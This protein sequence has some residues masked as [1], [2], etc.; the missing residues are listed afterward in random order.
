MKKQAQN[1]ELNKSVQL[2]IENL[3]E[4]N[5]GNISVQEENKELIEELTVELTDKQAEKQIMEDSEQ[6]VNKQ[7]SK[8]SKVL[9]ALFFVINIVVVACILVFQLKNEEVTAI[10]DLFKNLKWEYVLVIFMCFSVINLIHSTVFTIYIK[11]NTNR[12]RVN[13]AI[14]AHVIGRY[15]DNITPMGSGGQPF[16]IFY[17]NKRGLNAGASLSVTMGKYVIQQIAWMLFSVIAMIIA[18]CKGILFSSSLVGISCIIGFLANLF[19]ITLVLALSVSKKIG[20]KLVVKS[21]KLLEKIRIVKNYEKQYLKVMKIVNDYQTTM[22]SI[23][24]NLKQFLLNVLLIFLAY[25]IQYSIPFFIYCSFFGFNGDVYLEMVLL[26]LIIELAASFIPLPGGTGMSELSFTAVFAT[27]FGSNVFW[28]LLM[29]RFMS[30]YLYLILGIGFISYNY[31]VGD[32]KYKWLKRKWELE[33][34][35]N[36]FKEEQ[37][38]NYRKKAK[39]IKSRNNRLS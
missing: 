7:K 8:K 6:T 23:S 14:Q 18:G 13:L 11:T 29:W 16:Q 19:L 9:S 30:Y 1:Q 38:K 24:S 31:C 4:V 25:L 15:Y 39:Q 26:T 36:K 20:K 37:Y 34:E 12:K 21:L 2:E 28:A 27:F 3:P 32:K 5:S 33:A 10:G 17:F 35:S 22:Q